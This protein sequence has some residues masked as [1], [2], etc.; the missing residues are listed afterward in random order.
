MF[1]SDFKAHHS[2]ETA[3]VKVTNDLPKASDR[4]RFSILLDLSAAFDTIDH[5]IL[6]ERLQHKIKITGTALDWFKSYLDRFH[7]FHVNDVSSERTKVHPGVPQGSVLGPILFTLYTLPLENII[8]RYGISF[9]CYTDDTHLYLS[10]KPA[11]HPLARL[12]A[13]LKVVKDWMTSHFLLLN[14]DKTE[15]IVLGAK[16]PWSK[17]SD[18]ILFFWMALPCPRAQLRGT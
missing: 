17:L 9:H 4:G 3:L 13:C 7:F 16:H 2:T 1:Q 14:A 10:I 12:E 5:S 18:S 8:Q 15:V 11:S 6:L